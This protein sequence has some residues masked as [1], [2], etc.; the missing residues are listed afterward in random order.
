MASNLSF[1]Y[2]ILSFSLAI[3][4]NTPLTN[5]ARVEKFLFLASITA[6]LQAAD[7]GILFIYNI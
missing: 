3:V 6:S 4:L 5:P 1:G 7:V 2:S